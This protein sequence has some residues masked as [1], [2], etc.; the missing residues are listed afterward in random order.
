LPPSKIQSVKV[1]MQLLCVSM[2]GAGGG[3]GGGGTGGE[4]RGEGGNTHKIK[5]NGLGWG[6][7]PPVPNCA[8]RGGGVRPPIEDFKQLPSITV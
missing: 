6:V 8:V 7:E 5:K 4:G 3:G 1:R 2:E